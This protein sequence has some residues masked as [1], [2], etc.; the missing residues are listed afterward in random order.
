MVERIDFGILYTIVNARGNY[1]KIR[2]K[3]IIP[4]VAFLIVVGIVGYFAIF[5]VIESLTGQGIE[6]A[7]TLNKESINEMIDNSVTSVNDDLN[8]VANKALSIASL[9]S[10]V[11]TVQAA[12]EIALSGDIDDE[13]SP[14][15]QET[16]EILRRE[17]GPFI[18]GYTRNTSEQIL[19]LHFHLPNARSLVRLWRDGY[20]TTRDG[21]KVD[22]S[23]D[24]SSFRNTVIEIN[25]G[26]HKPITGIEIGRGGFAVRGIAP[27][28][29]S[30]GNILGSC[31]VLFPISNVIKVAKKSDNFNFAAYM[32]INK[33]EI[34]K[35]LQDAD[36][37]PILDGKY[38]RTDY[39]DAEITDS[40]VESDFL[41]KG[42]IGIEKQ[43]IDGYF[44]TA[45]P[46]TDYSGEAVGVMFLSYDISKQQA[47]IVDINEESHRRLQSLEIS[48]AIGIIVIIL[49]IFSIIFIVVRIISKSLAYASDTTVKV[50]GGDLSI[51]IESRSKDEIGTLL[52]AMQKMNNRL[53]DAMNEV[54]NS[55]V[56]VTQSSGQLAEAAGQIS[57]GATEQAANAEEVSA[58]LE[59][60]GANVQ[61]NADNAA[62]TEKIAARAAKD[63]EDGG[64]VV[65]EAV[66]AMN[67]IAN[68]INV[69]EEIARNTNLLSLNAAIEAARAGEHGKG[70]AV[71]AAEVG[72]LAA[73]SQKA[74]AEILALAK[75]TV[76]KAD[77]AGEKIQAIVPDI[78][79]TAELISE[80][81][82][83]S[84]E[85][86]SGIGQ[87]SQA[88][89]E[90]DKVIQQN[91][92][93]AEESSSMSEELTSQ[94]QQL[95]DLVSFF[96]LDNSS[97]ASMSSKTPVK[98]IAAPVI[99]KK[100]N[101][102]DEGFEEF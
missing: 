11:P 87:I 37:Y 15:S 88:M 79:K 71:V 12:Y 28:Y 80:I 32:D 10:N 65:I 2:N 27:V 23:D 75:S 7:A 68:K 42:H 39:T 18:E 13:Y 72:K 78:Q 14:Q 25:K 96:K 52:R 98:E 46:V 77:D 5:S 45:F 63:A 57:Q 40:L 55:A 4:V 50:A 101:Y 94:A 36:K 3:I 67:E 44:C 17:I 81:N 56:A 62:L 19:K 69:I 84:T 26:D 53:R 74:A 1:M 99:A 47:A 61:Q 21:V 30:D 90:L 48:F 33:L 66:E 51:T 16:R 8:R 92:A 59:Q 83:S 102:S 41:D 95:I 54:R 89:V 86:N 6:S 24:L 38:V 34:A 49:L 97:G 35:S 76:A 91:A 58:S 70:F 43:E 85:M 82:A 60:M 100:I 29:S 73:N 22:V 93:A 9:F 64:K 20:Q 31:E